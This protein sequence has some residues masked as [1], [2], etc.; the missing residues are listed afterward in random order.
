MLHEQVVQNLREKVQEL[1][2]NEMFE[3][4]LLKGSQVGL[5]PQPATDDIDAIMR[6]MMPRSA[7]PNVIGVPSHA[8]NAPISEGP[9]NS[10]ES[11]Y[12]FGAGMESL[13]GSEATLSGNPKRRKSLKG[14]RRG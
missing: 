12:D 11:R 4:A 7:G 6:S 5:E 3:Q 9:W 10:N 1:V 8:R 2:D 14:S 13:Q